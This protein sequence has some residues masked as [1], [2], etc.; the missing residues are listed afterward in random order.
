MK[1][2]PLHIVGRNVNWS[3]YFG[4]TIWRFLKK[5]KTDLPYDIV[6]P[7][8]GYT[9]RKW[10]QDFQEIYVFPCL[11]QHYSEYPRCGNN[12]NAHQWMNECIKMMWYIQN[13]IL[14]SYEKDTLPFAATWMDFK[15]IMLSKICQTD[16]QTST[17]WYHTR[18]WNLKKLNL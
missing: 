2:E 5:L 1:R 17:V 7:L 3:N 11:S 15:H 8:L 13:G 6:I 9:Q 14:F 4:K 12:P 18:I 16:R 10:K